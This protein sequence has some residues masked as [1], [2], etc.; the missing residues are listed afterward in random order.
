M[1]ANDRLGGGWQI[2]VGHEAL[3]AERD[4]ALS[5]AGRAE[6]DRGAA[7]RAPHTDRIGLAHPLLDTAS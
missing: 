2:Q 1:R 4:P 3:E 7:L 5:V 6:I